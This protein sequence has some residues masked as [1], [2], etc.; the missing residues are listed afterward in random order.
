MSS[1]RG[2]AWVVAQSALL[3]ALVVA[4]PFGAGAWHS[5]IGLFVGAALFVAGGALG[6]AG[7]IHLGP[8]RTAFPKPRPGAALV[9]RGV[10]GWIRHPLYSSLMLAGVGW[11]LLWQSVAALI[12]ALAVIAFFAAK[13]REE[14][15]WLAGV[16]P[17]H[18]EYRRRVRGRFLPGLF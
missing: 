16:F 17:E 3:L 10:Y 4:G 11:A 14:E 6:I 5:G 15:R 8:N 7:V 1:S 9:R 2:L 18:D 13:A 12:A